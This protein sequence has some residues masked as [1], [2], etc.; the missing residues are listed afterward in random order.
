[1]A[2]LLY[3]ATTRARHTLVLA[4]DEEIFARSNGEMQNGAQLKSLLGD[5]QASAAR[6]S[7]ALQRRPN[8]LRRNVRDGGKATG[9]WSDGSADADPPLV[10]RGTIQTRARSRRRFRRANSIRVVTTRKSIRRRRMNP[11]NSRT[12]DRRGP[13]DGRHAGN[14]VRPLVARASCSE[15]HG[16]NRTSWK[17][18]FEEHQATSPVPKRS[19][20]EWKLLHNIEERFRVSRSSHAAAEVGRASE[21]PFFWRM[22][23]RSA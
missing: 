20:D 21:M 15:F 18:T 17:R 23:E 7:T 8:R 14:T 13:V 5:K 22:D 6:I 12:G 4:L 9:R 3:V 11:T 19:A 2:R 16:V 10:E 1:M